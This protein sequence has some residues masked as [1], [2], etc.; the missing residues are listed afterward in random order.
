[1][2]ETVGVNPQADGTVLKDTSA[3]TEVALSAADID[4]VEVARLT[5]GK[6]SFGQDKQPTVLWGRNGRSSLGWVDEYD[7][8]TKVEGQKTLKFWRGEW[9]G[10]GMELSGVVMGK[11]FVAFVHPRESMW[12]KEEGEL[13]AEIISAG[14]I[15]SLIAPE[16]VFNPAFIEARNIADRNVE[17]YKTAHPQS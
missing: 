1:M 14:K 7:G 2:G 10:T 16:G 8:L 17:A 12:E 13:V 5:G 15:K 4:L 3:P 9:G 6:V 11:D